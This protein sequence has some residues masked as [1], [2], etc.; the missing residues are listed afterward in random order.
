MN[1]EILEPSRFFLCKDAEAPT[2]AFGWI[3][4][5]SLGNFE[6]W[7]MWSFTARWPWIRH[8]KGFVKTDT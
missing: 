8:L 6:W 2:V 5:T 3:N 7:N 1:I 4:E